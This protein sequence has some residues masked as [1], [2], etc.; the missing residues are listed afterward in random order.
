MSCVPGELLVSAGPCVPTFMNRC[1]NGVTIL[2]FG[3]SVL[4]YWDVFRISLVSLLHGQ[5]CVSNCEAFFTFA[6]T[7]F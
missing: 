4:L 3:L 7:G 2:L 5:S 6:E 1:I